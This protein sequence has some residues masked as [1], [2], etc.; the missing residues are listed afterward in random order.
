MI[1]NVVF[2][3]VKKVKDLSKFSV[4]DIM[5]SRF[6]LRRNKGEF[7]IIF[8]MYFSDYLLF[9]MSIGIFFVDFFYF[10]GY[11]D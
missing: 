3:R 2:C 7:V 8:Y 10:Y 6:L 5:K 4:Y 11:D 9:Y 1:E